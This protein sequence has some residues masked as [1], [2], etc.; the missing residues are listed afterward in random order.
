MVEFA[1]VVLDDLG[2]RSH[3]RRDQDVGPVIS[4]SSV[5]IVVVRCR[6]NLLQSLGIIAAF[7]HRMRSLLLRPIFDST[8]LGLLCSSP[9]L[10]CNW[11]LLK[12]DDVWDKII[13]TKKNLKIAVLENV[14][15]LK[16]RK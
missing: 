10:I 6:R 1:L 12:Y 3:V 13:L 14:L 4:P 8:F 15:R 7:R 5:V 11:N 9:F 16:K 2:A